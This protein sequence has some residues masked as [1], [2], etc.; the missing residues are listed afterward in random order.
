MIFKKRK[1][2]EVAEKEKQSGKTWLTVGMKLTLGVAV[3]SNLCIGVLL[4]DNWQANREVGA[5]TAEVIKTVDRLNKDLRSRMVELQTRFLTIPKA[6]ET[7]PAGKIVNWLETNYTLTGETVLEGRKNY[8]RRFKRSQRRDISKGRFVVVRD[9]QDLTVYRGVMTAEGEFADK[10]SVVKVDTDDAGR[11]AREIKV[12]IQTALENSDNEEALKI[13]VAQLTADLADDVLRAEKSRNEILYHVEEIQEKKAGLVALRGEKQR[14][15]RIIAGVTIVVNLLVLYLLAW[16]NVEKPLRVLTTAIEQ[17]KNNEE[18]DIP[19]QKRK[20][21]IGVLAGALKGFQ[22]ALTNLKSEDQRKIEE[23]KLVNELIDM[24][25]DIIEELRSKAGEMHT[26][27]ARLNDLTSETE[28]E[29]LSAAD[30]A[31]NTVMRT[32]TVLTS[33]RQLARAVENISGQ[34]DRQNGLIQEISRV[35]RRSRERIT[36]LNRASDEI[37]GIVKMVTDI[38]SQ[39]KLL[40]LN[41]RIEAARAG[42]AG[43]GFAVVAAEVR[44]LSTQTEEAN[45]EIAGRLGAIQEAGQAI[46]DCTEK[47]DKGIEALI[48]TSALIS[49]ATQEQQAVTDKIASNVDDTAE[50]SRSVCRRISSVKDAAENSRFIAGNVHAYSREISESLDHLLGETKQRL[51]RMGQGGKNDVRIIGEITKGTGNDPAGAVN[52]FKAICSRAA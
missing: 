49:T 44:A 14:T 47:T 21:K 36:E 27:A 12:A 1:K 6:L 52:G 15:T 34:V 4:Y 39:T 30:S 37:D 17:I 50:E 42:S 51:S 32:D 24:M 2:A 20:D 28:G 46:I 31:N 48:S 13:K 5:T 26:A 16:L 29:T 9:G 43:K 41:A 7:D 8:A 18:C 25:S 38:S 19:Y 10:V 23:K 35:A 33:T 40:A 3:V 45:Q 11:A 22:A